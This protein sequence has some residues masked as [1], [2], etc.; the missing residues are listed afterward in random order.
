MMRHGLGNT[1]PSDIGSIVSSR[2]EEVVQEV[3]VQET[4]TE[5]HRGGT[6]RPGQLHA[7]LNGIQRL[8]A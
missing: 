1:L 4:E 6:S 8:T 3:R 5:T 7:D 2:R